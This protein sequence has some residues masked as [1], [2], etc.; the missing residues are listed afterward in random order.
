MHVMLA[1]VH[2]IVPA[3]ELDQKADLNNYPG[4][5]LRDLGRKH[6]TQHQVS[7]VIRYETPI[8]GSISGVS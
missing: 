6:Q 8:N 2:V 4:Q 1:L 3:P 7:S 5:L